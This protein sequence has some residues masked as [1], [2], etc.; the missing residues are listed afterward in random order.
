MDPERFF[1]VRQRIRRA[2]LPDTELY[3]RAEFERM[4]YEDARRLRRALENNARL[5]RQ[6]VGGPTRFDRMLDDMGDAGQGP[7]PRAEPDQVVRQTE[8]GKDGKFVGRKA[9]AVAAPLV[10]K[11]AD[12]A[13]NT[14][15]TLAGS[16]W[17][18]D[19][20]DMNTKGDEYGFALVCV[21]VPSR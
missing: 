5:A 2:G 16:V 18:A 15:P 6:A 1:D 3:R 11:V 20:M 9:G 21:N 12:A 17:Q 10:D 13:G 14:Q 19:L 8:K 7:R 4:Q